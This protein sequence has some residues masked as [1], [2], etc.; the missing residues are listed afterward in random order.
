M[1]RT[2]VLSLQAADEDEDEEADTPT[3][4]R[5][6]SGQQQPVRD[7]PAVM[8]CLKRGLKI[9]HAAQQ[10]LNISRKT[11]DTTPVLLFLEIL[12]K[13]LYYFD[14]GLPPITTE[15]LKARLLTLEPLRWD[16]IVFSKIL[17][18]GWIPRWLL[19]R[20]SA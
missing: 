8:S 9:A 14:Q 6:G 17:C 12:N 10:Q 4:Q 18:I 1:N 2:S 7:A 20:V 19:S 15:V 3:E 16:Q 11:Q 13:Y 5:Q